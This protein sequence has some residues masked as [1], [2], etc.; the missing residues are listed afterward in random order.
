MNH[1][2]LAQASL[3]A[4]I[5][6]SIE[7]LQERREKIL[8]NLGIGR[9]VKPVKPI[10]SVIPSPVLTAHG[11]TRSYRRKSKPVA[12][13]ICAKEGKTAIFAAAQGLASHMRGIHGIGK[14]KRALNDLPVACP[15]CPERFR[16]NSGLTS[17]LRGAIHRD[18]IKQNPNGAE[19]TQ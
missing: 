3:L 1:D 12:C 18:A 8:S 17:H 10:P 14:K 11:S 9:I 4:G 16:N 2:Q 15:Y 6:A 5:E 19:V 7:A 13:E